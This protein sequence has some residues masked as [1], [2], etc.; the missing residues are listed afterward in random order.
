[1]SLI[2]SGLFGAGRRRRY[3]CR[4]DPPLADR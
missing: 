1:M 3:G 4:G 2:G